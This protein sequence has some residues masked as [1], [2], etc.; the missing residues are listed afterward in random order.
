MSVLDIY[1]AMISRWRPGRAW[2]QEH[3]PQTMA[4][5]ALT[6]A[7]PSIAATWARNFKSS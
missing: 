1:V 5:V 6:E 4:A 7:H 2:L 3:C